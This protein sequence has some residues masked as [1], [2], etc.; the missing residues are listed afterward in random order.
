M[1]DLK[2]CPFCGGVAGFSLGK[3][4]DGTDWHYVECIECEAAGPEVKYADHN[5]SVKEALVEAWN[6]RAG[7][8]Q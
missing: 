3:M 6:T 1:S 8:S 4:G 2:P 5:I 7:E